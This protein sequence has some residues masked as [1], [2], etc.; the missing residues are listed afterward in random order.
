[1][2]NNCNYGVLQTVSFFFFFVCLFF[3]GKSQLTNKNIGREIVLEEHKSSMKHCVLTAHMDVNPYSYVLE[4]HDYF[5]SYKNTATI[6][7]SQHYKDNKIESVFPHFTISMNEMIS[8]ERDPHTHKVM[9]S[10]EI[11]QW[12]FL[13]GCVFFCFVFVFVFSTNANLRVL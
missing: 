9:Y 4:F 3:H 1:M 6:H 2:K 8:K 13:C 7:P 10:H 11:C 5:D 12:Y